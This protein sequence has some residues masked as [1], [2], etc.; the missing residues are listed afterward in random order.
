MWKKESRT[1]K[2]R[3]RLQRA[4]DRWI[5][6]REALMTAWP[7][8]LVVLLGFGVAFYFVKPAPPR[9][10]VMS[11]G[12][13]DGRYHAFALRYKEIFARNGITLELRLSQ[14]SGENLLRLR[15][16][17]ADIA[18]VQG[19]VASNWNGKD[20]WEGLYTLGSAFYEPLWVFVRDDRDGQYPQ[21]LTDLAQKRI[22]VIQEN[23]NARA[24]AYRLLLANDITEK[25]AQIRPATRA[26]DEFAA[27]EAL[28]Q[29]EIDALFIIAAPESPIV[30]VL[31]RTFGIR[32]MDFQRAQA[33]HRH[34]PYLF[35]LLMPEGGVDLAYNFPPQ[36]TELLA[37]TA[38]LVVQEDLHP[39]LQ[40]LMLAALREVHGGSGFF[41]EAGEFPA[42]RDSDF[43]L[44]P[45]AERFHASGPPFLQRYL[46]FW[47]A[48][49][50]DRFLILALPLLTLL[51]P[52]LRFAPAIYSWRIRSR[53]C[54]VYGE[55]KFL[56][57]DLLRRRLEALAPEIHAD[58]M[59]RLDAIEADANRM[60]VPRS[61]SDLRYT[62]KMHIQMVRER[63]AK[64]RDSAD[65]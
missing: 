37:A 62:L 34:F 57:N 40:S 3:L 15:Q 16:G 22:T 65:A 39:A 55:L 23:S 28:Q 51:L 27:A 11:T 56:E 30:Q 50:A 54:R 1:L 44:T 32:L 43:P 18:Y 49:L 14:G 9:H 24:L 64:M 63:L 45:T 26:Q 33:Y 47:L 58:F 5:T 7:L 29:G 46:P 59:A 20:G 21:R 8:T 19:G 48:V 52:I 41:Q 17:E 31:L 10:L 6:W 36:D 2:L 25:S 60:S 4:R 38:N 35:R 61:F 12:R 42:Y 13:E 53:V